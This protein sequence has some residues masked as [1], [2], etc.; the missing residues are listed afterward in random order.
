MEELSAEGRRGRPLAWLANQIRRNPADPVAA[1]RALSMLTLHSFVLAATPPLAHDGPVNSAEF[2]PDEKQ[3]LTAS[4]DFTVRFW[5]AAT[6]GLV[7]TITNDTGIVG[8]RYAARGTRVLLV[9]RKEAAR[10]HDASGAFL[11]EVPRLSRGIHAVVDT[12]NGSWLYAAHEDHTVSRWDLQ[13]GKRA[14]ATPPLSGSISLMEASPAGEYLAVACDDSTVHVLEGSTGRMVRQAGPFGVS[15][16][17]L[18][19]TPDST[20]LFIALQEG[21]RIA[22]WNFHSSEQ[23]STFE[24]PPTIQ[25]RAMHFTPDGRRL[26]TSSWAAPPRIWDAETLQLLKEP[27]GLDVQWWSDYRVSCDGR[28]LAG[29]A[30]NGMAQIWE[31]ETGQQILEPFEH[32]GWIRTIV[33]NSSNTHVLTASQDGTARLWDIRMRSAGGLLS[34]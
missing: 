3:V 10:V 28:R 13:S 25:M 2:S 32:Q 1:S 26:I 6:G 22:T 24:P 15:I 17:H 19:F 11:F 29:V 34:V 12:P 31:I 9:T 18:R 4:D 30:Q 23:V 8:A 5:D 20:R 27:A 7:R 16:N 33:F 21:H 14:P